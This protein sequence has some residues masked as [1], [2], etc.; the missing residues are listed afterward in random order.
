MGAM[1]GASPIAQLVKNPPAIQ[2]TLQYRGPSVSKEST[3]NTEAWERLPT[4]VFWPRELNGLY[5]RGGQKE[6]DAD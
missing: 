3:C 1:G 6:S 5:S 2:R 4:T